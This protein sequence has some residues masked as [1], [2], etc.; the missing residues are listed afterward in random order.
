MTK[1]MLIG[2][3][4]WEA[5]RPSCNHASELVMIKTESMQI[6]KCAQISKEGSINERWCQKWLEV[7]RL[8]KQV[9][10]FQHQEDELEE[11]LREFNL[12]YNIKEFTLNVN[13]NF[14]FASFNSDISEEC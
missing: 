14:M 2:F 7:Y 9:N 5:G 8:R 13:Y 12:E 6:D 10:G 4:V 11:Y 1:V 3:Y